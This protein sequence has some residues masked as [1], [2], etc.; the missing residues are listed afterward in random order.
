MDGR[1]RL[2]LARPDVECF[3]AFWSPRYVV[4]LLA[5]ITVNF[6]ADQ[7]LLLCRAGV[8]RLSAK[9]VLTGAVGANRATLGYF[10]YANFFVDSFCAAG[11]F[12]E[13][14]LSNLPCGLR[15]IGP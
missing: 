13:R 10:K 12:V 15:G 6:F 5:S 11:G 14:L 2:R 9:H 1:A 7:L 8:G 4:V 3:W